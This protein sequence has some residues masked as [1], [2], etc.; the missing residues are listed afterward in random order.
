MTG[1]VCLDGLEGEGASGERVA[2]PGPA[3]S[4]AA[5]AGGRIDDQ[6]GGAGYVRPTRPPPMTCRNSLMEAKRIIGLWRF[7]APMVVCEPP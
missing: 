4:R 6:E 1:P 2:Q 5:V 7:S 3:S